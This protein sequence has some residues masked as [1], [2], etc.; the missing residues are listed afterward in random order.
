MIHSTYNIKNIK[1]Y[2]QVQ[3]KCTYFVPNNSHQKAF[4]DMSNKPLFM[5]TVPS[6]FQPECVPETAEDECKMINGM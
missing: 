3:N 6:T 1:D 5:I 2:L 4:F